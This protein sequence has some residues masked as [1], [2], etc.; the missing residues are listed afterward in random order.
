M[1]TNK[2]V[3][4]GASPLK[5]LCFKTQISAFTL[6]MENFSKVKVSNWAGLPHPMIGAGE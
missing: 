4:T 5:F 2:S 1:I 6:S 3:Q